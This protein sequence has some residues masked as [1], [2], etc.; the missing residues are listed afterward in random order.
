MRFMMLVKSSENSGM[1]PKELM[2][3]IGKLAE[4]AVK[5]GTM[6]ESGG[7]SSTAM[8]TRVRLSGGKLSKIDGPFTETKEV[9]GGFAMFELKSRQEAIDSAVKFMEL[10][11]QYWPGW[12]GETEVRQIF[13]PEDFPP[14]RRCHGVVLR[15]RDE[16]SLRRSCREFM[17]LGTQRGICCSFRSAGLPP[18]H[19]R[20]LW[21]AAELVVSVAEGNL[22]AASF[23]C[24]VI[25]NPSQAEGE[26]SLRHYLLAS[27]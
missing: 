22:S 2:D 17:P 7:L 5:A 21:I 14:A 24:G 20:D 18:G 12:E 10:H 27:S 23:S 19:Q 15:K 8:S 13:G 9:V 4:E 1:P 26:E 3:A 6:L 16:E 25:L 11:K